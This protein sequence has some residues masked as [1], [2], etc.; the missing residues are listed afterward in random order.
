MTDFYKDP[1]IIEAD[2]V[3]YMFPLSKD[4]RDGDGIYKVWL[5]DI[6][7]NITGGPKS[8]KA[9]YIKLRFY[10]LEKSIDKQVKEFCEYNKIPPTR[11]GWESYR[12]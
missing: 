11:E 6:D 8:V 2:S 4:S 10:D 3:E 7:G 1:E 9:N 5:L 12:V